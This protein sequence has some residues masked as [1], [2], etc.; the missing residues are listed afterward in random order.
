MLSVLLR[1]HRITLAYGRQE[2]LAVLALVVLNAITQTFAVFSL[3]PFLGA[4]IDMPTFRASR[5]GEAFI[6]LVG[7]RSDRTL[8]ILIGLMSLISLIAANAFNLIAEYRKNHY[9]FHI[10]H[11]L[12]MRIVDD[13]LRRNYVY[14]LRADGS[15]LLKNIIEDVNV[16]S[17]QI[18]SSVIDIVARIVIITTI[19]SVVFIADPEITSI[20]VI[21]IAL[22]YF[23]VMHPLRR[24][25]A[26]TSDQIMTRIRG[27]YFEVWQTFN[28]IKPIFISGKASYF[29][30]KIETT[31]AAVAEEMPRVPLYAMLPRSALEVVV[32]G[33]MIVWVLSIIITG[34]NLVEFVPLIGFIAVAAYRLMPAIQIVFSQI[35]SITTARQALDELLRVIDEQSDFEAL[36]RTAAK[37]A[38]SAPILD[39]AHH[40]AFHNVSFTHIGAERAS[41]EDASFIIRRGERVALV[42][43]TGSGKS[44]L[45]DLLIGLLEPSSGTISVDGT[46]L[47]ADRLPAWRRAIGYVPQE[48]FLLNG[49][50]RENIAFGIPREHIIDKQ[51]TE[52]A[53]IA[54]IWDFIDKERLEGLESIVGERGVRLSG[55]QRQ[56]IAVARALY[57]DPKVLLLDEATSALDPHTEAVILAGIGKLDPAPTVVAVTHRLSTVERYDRVLFVLGGRIVAIG[58][59]DQLMRTS[60]EFNAFLGSLQ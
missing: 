46:V 24:Y 11:R 18:C 28:G 12:R 53:R 23:A 37:A 49:T 10:G 16:F 26:R 56:R 54:A 22:F 32:F 20:S 35:I 7:N 44:T 9:A 14:F 52:A 51:I 17:N 3:L 58:E 59:L 4:A 34:D 40:I 41:I 42:G 1:I 29:R 31:S 60:P 30:A 21:C 6:A 8:I 19:V 43:P 57:T 13:I 48:T 36:S 5:V 50:I 33:G 55:G 47:T 15:I 45:V 38:A 27:L 2:L 39:F 25:A